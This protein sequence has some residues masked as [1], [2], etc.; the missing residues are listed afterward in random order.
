MNVTSENFKR[1]SDW[2]RH[3]LA[4]QPVIPKDCKR[5]TL[6]A[7]CL[8]LAIHGSCGR[9]CYVSDSSLSKEVGVSRRHLA[10]YRKLAV[11]LE[12]FT[13][14]GEKVNRVESLDVSIPQLQPDMPEWYDAPEPERVTPKPVQVPEDD[15]DS[16]NHLPACHDPWC[17]GCKL[18][19]GDSTCRDPRL[20]R[21]DRVVVTW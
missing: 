18:L 7:F 10:K 4:S 13:P 8:T 1:Y 12:W 15:E 16:G 17:G 11:A 20:L 9:G 14:S 21:G 19:R 5:A 3:V 6:I 2:Q